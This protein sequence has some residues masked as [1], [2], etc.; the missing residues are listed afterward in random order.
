MDL[1]DL[2]EGRNKVGRQNA[3]EPGIDP[4]HHDQRHR[5][6]TK[7]PL[8][9]AQQRAFVGDIDAGNPQRGTDPLD[10]RLILRHRH[11]HQVRRC[12][13]STDA[14]LLADIDSSRARFA[15]G[16]HSP[17]Q[18]HLAL[19]QQ[20]GADLLTQRAGRADHQDPWHSSIMA[21]RWATRKG[22]G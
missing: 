16:P 18:R 5:R 15:L 4:T 19:S 8:G 21:H 11:H 2:I 7:L 6:S 22:L 13:R 10:S 9:G 12:G 1:R 17:D 14:H 20:R 3:A